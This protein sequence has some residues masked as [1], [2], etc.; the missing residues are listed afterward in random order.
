MCLEVWAGPAGADAADQSD[1]IYEPVAMADVG[2]VGRV[3][4]KDGRL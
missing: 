4:W 2:V 3:A 1:A